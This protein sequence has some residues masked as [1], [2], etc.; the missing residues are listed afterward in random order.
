MLRLFES[1]HNIQ[2][3]QPLTITD[4]N[5]LMAIAGPNQSITI[6]DLEMFK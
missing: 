4:D 1:N 2:S 5:K 6:I 3:Q